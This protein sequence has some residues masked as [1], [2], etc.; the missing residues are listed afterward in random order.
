MFNNAKINFRERFL[1]INPHTRRGI[2]QTGTPKKL[3]MHWIGES[4]TMTPDQVYDYW[5]S[6]GKNAYDPYASAHCII[7][8]YDV[9]QTMP[10]NEIAFHVGGDKYTEKAHE[11][12]GDFG[13]SNDPT[14][15]Y[16]TP[17][18]YTIGIELCPAEL[19]SGKFSDDTIDAAISVFGYLC[20]EFHLN[21]LTDIVMHNDIYIKDCPRYAINN[22][23]WF[24]WFRNSV[25]LRLEQENS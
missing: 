10:F 8:D 15:A 20:K 25:S 6:L 13:V 7:K 24:Q 21:P 4:A 9:L 11:W 2:I 16:S 22:P 19:P 5:N 18:N 23:T 12:F 17:N 1:D 14:S 3:V